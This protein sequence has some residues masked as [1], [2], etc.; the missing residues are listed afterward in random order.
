MVDDVL[1]NNLK[2]Q[3]GV[4]ILAVVAGALTGGAA[5]AGAVYGIDGMVKGHRAGLVAELAG[6][7]KTDLYKEFLA[8]TDKT[9][10]QFDALKEQIKQASKLVEGSSKDLS[11]QQ[12]IIIGTVTLA[13]VGI[14]AGWVVHA[15]HNHKKPDPKIDAA[16][17]SLEDQKV[18]TAQTSHAV[19]V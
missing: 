2:K 5:A 19:T 12:K 16:T 15:I 9:D 4:D 13:A 11:V 7:K 17:A 18:I 6:I 8:A 1:E 10:S 3:G 14:L